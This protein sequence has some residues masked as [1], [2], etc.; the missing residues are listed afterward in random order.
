MT[1]DGGY[2]S[3]GCLEPLFLERF[4]NVLGLTE[5]GDKMMSAKLED[6]LLVKQTSV[7]QLAKHEPTT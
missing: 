6:K 3:V 1:S 7:R 5:L 4:L 2:M